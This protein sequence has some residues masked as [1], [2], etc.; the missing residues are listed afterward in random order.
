MSE[1]N[2]SRSPLTKSNPPIHPHGVIHFTNCISS[3]KTN[4]NG[5]ENDVF[6]KISDARLIV[7]FKTGDAFKTVVTPI[8]G[9]SVQG[10]S[11]PGIVATLAQERKN[12]EQNIPLENQPIK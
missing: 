7:S 5:P 9:I 2:S 4:P 10:P 6:F 12:G 11:S 3:T 1:R 8:C